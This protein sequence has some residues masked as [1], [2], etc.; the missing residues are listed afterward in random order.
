MEKTKILTIL[1]SPAFRFLADSDSKFDVTPNFLKLKMMRRLL[2]RIGL[3]E[4]DVERI[5]RMMEFKYN[6]WKDR[7]WFKARSFQQLV[8]TPVPPGFDIKEH[9][10]EY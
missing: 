10:L 7:N 2:G 6:W 5:S 4:E 1:G 3:G 9:L 8:N